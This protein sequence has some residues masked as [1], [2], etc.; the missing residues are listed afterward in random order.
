MVIFSR[1]ESADERIKKLLELIVNPKNAV[2]VSDDK[3]IKFF[4]GACRARTQSA[5][6]FLSFVDELGRA[7]SEVP[8]EEISYTQM[9]KINEELRK[10]WLS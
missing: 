7:K 9:H 2:V 8:E 1:S 5:Q 10:L 6:E 3:E 4:A